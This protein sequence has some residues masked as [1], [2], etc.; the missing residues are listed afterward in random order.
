MPGICAGFLMVTFYV[1]RHGE[2]AANRGGVFQGHLDVPLSEKGRKQADLVAEALRD[3]CFDA[4]YSSD[5][6]RAAET[7]R[8][9]MRHHDCSLVLD[10]RLREING[11]KMQGMTEEEVA[12]EFP[13]FARALEEDRYNVRRPGGESY[14]DLDGRIARALDDIYAWHAAKPGGATVGVVSH[15]GA[16]RCMLK[17]SD[18]DPLLIRRVVGNCT[19][20]VLEC[21][22]SGWRAV[23]T[24]DGAHL[25]CLTDE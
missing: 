7:A 25:S 9:I 18:P 1:I 6:S 5:L 4:V 23:T 8:A 2:T 14:A 21:D 20:T 17:A 11:G 3:V 19:I 12:R 16:I 22:E 24:G 15:G 13:E 10:R